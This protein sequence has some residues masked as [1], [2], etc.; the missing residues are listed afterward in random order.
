MFVPFSRGHCLFVC[1]CVNFLIFF[2]DVM[3][4]EK[5]LNIVRISGSILRSPVSSKGRDERRHSQSFIELHGE[6]HTDS[7]TLQ[8]TLLG[9]KIIR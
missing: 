4:G 3:L 7:F 8:A 9:T 2:G 5:C 1:H 6:D